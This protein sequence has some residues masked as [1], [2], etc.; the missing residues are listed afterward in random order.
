MHTLALFCLFCPMPYLTQAYCTFSHGAR[1]AVK[2]CPKHTELHF[3]LFCCEPAHKHP[4]FAHDKQSVLNVC[5]M[6]QVHTGL[7]HLQY[8]K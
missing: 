6:H 5:H 1:H 8:N 2:K 7:G 4:L 3:I